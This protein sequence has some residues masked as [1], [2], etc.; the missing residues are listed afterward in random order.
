MDDNF[1]I[2]RILEP[3]ERD[4]WRVNMVSTSESN[5]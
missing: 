2:A 5:Q 1:M 3:S 4:R